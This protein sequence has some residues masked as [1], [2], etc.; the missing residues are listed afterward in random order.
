VSLSFTRAITV[1]PGGVPTSRQ[2]RSL[3]RAVND[4]LRG[5]TDGAWR[6]AW[7]TYNQARLVRNPDASGWLFPAEHEFWSLW[8]RFAQHGAQWPAAGPGDPEGCNLGSVAPQF[9]FGNAILSDKAARLAEL[10]PMRVNGVAP[11]TPA[12]LWTLGKLQRGVRTLDGY[13]YAPALEAA[14]TVFQFAFHPLVFHGK[15]YGGWQPRAPQDPGTPWCDDFGFNYANW[16]NL[17]PY[18]TALAADVDTSQLHGTITTVDGLPRVTYAGSCPCGSGYT[19]AGHVLYQARYPFAW[20]LAVS[21]G[22]VD[23]DGN[24]EYDVD[25]LPTA[26]WVEGPYDGAPVLRHGDPGHILR[27]VHAYHSEFRGSDAQRTPDTFDISKI[28]F[29]NQA[30]FTR[31]YALAGAFGVGGDAGL[32]AIYPSVTTTAHGSFRL[33]GENGPWLP[34]PGYVI[35]GYQASATGIA[36]PLRVSVRDGAGRVYAT[37]PLSPVQGEASGVSWGSVAQPEDLYADVTGAVGTGR[38]TV[39]AT[40]LVEYRPQI[41]DAYLVSRMATASGE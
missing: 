20:Y 24:C 39:E 23:A 36:G 10:F 40:E 28:A 11:S 6:V 38:V 22:T 3:A 27:M 12:E 8:S 41:W 13:Q 7:A 18:W 35:A 4:R 15:T 34:H 17:T 16:P 29:A 26:D 9:V 1:E 31:Q 25:R 14:E 32:V 37:I 21:R 30:F 2:Q 19:A 5:P 33:V